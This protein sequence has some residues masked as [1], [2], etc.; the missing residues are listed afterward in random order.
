MVPE[1]WIPNRNRFRH[2]IDTIADHKADNDA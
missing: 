2:S 1:R